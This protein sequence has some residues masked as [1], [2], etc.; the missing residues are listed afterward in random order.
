M[1]D[2]LCAKKICTLSDNIMPE[3]CLPADK[4]LLGAMRDC[5]DI[6]ELSPLIISSPRAEAH[7]IPV[8]DEILG[9]KCC[10]MK[11]CLT[12][13]KVRDEDLLESFWTLACKYLIAVG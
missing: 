13:V 12:A 8:G 6:E 1:T 10:A 7:E 5:G 2:K 3:L 11:L 4:T 9:C